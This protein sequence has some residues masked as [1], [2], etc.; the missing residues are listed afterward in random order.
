[1]FIRQDRRWEDELGYVPVVLATLDAESGVQIQDRLGQ[2]RKAL[3]KN[4]KAWDVDQCSIP[5][6]K[7]RGKRKH[8]VFT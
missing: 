1:M 4:K 7:G 3:S 2:C 8:L 6:L 5:V